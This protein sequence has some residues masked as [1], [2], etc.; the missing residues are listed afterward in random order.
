ME[1]VVLLIGYPL[2][3]EKARTPRHDTRQNLV[4][5]FL[6]TLAH[7]IFLAKFNAIKLT[8]LGVFHWWSRAITKIRVEKFFF[9]KFF[10]LYTEI[11][12]Y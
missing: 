7:K 2:K 5:V 10:S 8:T 12:S 4:Q 6:L 1:R 11:Y 9:L 3:E